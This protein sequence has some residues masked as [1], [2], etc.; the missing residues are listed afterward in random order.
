MFPDFDSLPLSAM[1]IR[2]HR[3]SSLHTHDFSELVVVLSGAAMH[4]SPGGSYP[5]AAGDVFVLH[6][7]Q[8]HGY[9]QTRS[10]DLVNILFRMNELSIIL[11]DVDS[12][13]GYHALFT[14]E[15]ASRARDRFAG[16]LRLTADQLI[17]IEDRL[18][19]FLSE[20]EDR[21]AGWQFT[22]IAQFMLIVS[23]LCRFYSQ[24]DNPST[25]SLMHLGGVIGHIRRRYAE[26]ITLDELARVAG[27]SRRTLTR[28][29]VKIVGL[30]PIDYLI[31]ERIRIASKLLNETN[32]NVTEAALRVG[33]SDSNYFS[34]QFRAITGL[35]PK[36]TR[37]GRSRTVAV[38]AE[39][40]RRA[41][42]TDSRPAPFLDESALP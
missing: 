36:E 15:P 33:F 32:I 24:S 22:A 28:E 17:R 11:R 25:R 16:R 14:L 26:H 6:G 29:F 37:M 2:N 41:S 7:D 12:L 42:D 10:L 39:L 31:R 3:D 9:S 20:T 38:D 18:R 30:S 19:E 27:M 13:P 34:R 4:I 1:R 21:R 5:I 8:A 23:D 35:S 40:S